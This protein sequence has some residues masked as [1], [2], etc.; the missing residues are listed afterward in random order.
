[1]VQK[2]GALN[3]TGLTGKIKADV[4][5]AYMFEIP[6]LCMLRV[7]EAGEVPVV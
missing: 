4:F 1:M 3:R 6:V 5:L 7:S 2:G